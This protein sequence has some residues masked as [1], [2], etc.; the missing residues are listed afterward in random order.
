MLSTP[1]L[2]GRSV[3]QYIWG[4]DKKT[5]RTRADFLRKR[6]H[7]TRLWKLIRLTTHDAVVLTRLS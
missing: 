3:N 2:N 7:M 6:S 4:K 5:P 1:R